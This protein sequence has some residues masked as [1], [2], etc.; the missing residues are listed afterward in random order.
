MAGRNVQDGVEEANARSIRGY[1][2]DPGKPERQFTGVRQI[3]HSCEFL[4]GG[5]GYFPPSGARLLSSIV[6]MLPF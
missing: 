1:L 3:P 6:V 5:V 4:I 2:D